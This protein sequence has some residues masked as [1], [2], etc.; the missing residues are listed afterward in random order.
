MRVGRMQVG[1]KSFRR[2]FV[3][4]VDAD[5]KAKVFA[6]MAAALRDVKAAGL[7]ALVVADGDGEVVGV[8]FLCSPEAAESLLSA[9]PALS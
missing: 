3:G 5:G 2:E 6:S 9:P 8:L 4:V 7:D 1:V